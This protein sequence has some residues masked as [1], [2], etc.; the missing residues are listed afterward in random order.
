MDKA[1]SEKERYIA[2]ETL[3]E[4]E[5]YIEEDEGLIDALPPGFANWVVTVIAVV[6]SIVHL[7]AAVGI[8]TP[9]ILRGIHVMFVTG[10]TFLVFPVTKKFRGKIFWF[11]I[12]FSLV[13]I[14]PIIYL[15][16][17]FDNIIDRAVTPTHWDVLMGSI[18]ILVL[19]E[20]NRRSTGIVM[21]ITALCF[22]AYAIIGPLLPKP[23]T[24]RGYDIPRIVGHL[25]ITMEGIFGVPIDVSSTFIILF[26]IF[27]AFLQYSGAVKFYVDFSF[28]LM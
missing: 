25:Y 28:A 19:L 5:K 6:M 9:H 24:H 7:Y 12:L 23:W 26:T 18:L 2:E 21:A 17:D 13:S 1:P 16:V 22:M 3:K 20:T 8:I 11:D 27:G 10:L 15:I 4:A 14:I